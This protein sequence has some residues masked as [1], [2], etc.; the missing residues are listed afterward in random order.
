MNADDFTPLD[1]FLLTN[2][3]AAQHHRKIRQSF[4]RMVAGE[5]EPFAP[6]QVPGILHDTFLRLAR[7]ARYNALSAG[8]T[9]N[10]SK[11]YMP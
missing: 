4:D 9:F 2:Q 1:H 3:I 6:D 7:Q 8:K 10:P 5:I 11:S